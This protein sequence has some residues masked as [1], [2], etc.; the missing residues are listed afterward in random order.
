MRYLL[1]VVCLLLSGCNNPKCVWDKNEIT[2]F[3]SEK[4]SWTLDLDKLEKLCEDR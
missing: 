2:F 4:E 1:I 3:Y